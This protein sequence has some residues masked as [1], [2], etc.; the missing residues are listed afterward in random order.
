MMDDREEI[1]HNRKLLLCPTTE[2]WSAPELLRECPQCH[3]FLLYC[4]ACNKRLVSLPRSRRQANPCHHFRIIFTDGACTNNGRPEAKAGVGVAYGNDA[5]S[6]LSISITDL[7]DDFPVRSNQRAE[8]Y[9]AI[10]GLEFL[11]EADEINSH[12]QTGKPK[13]QAEAWIIATDSEY[14]VKGMTEWLP[15]WRRNNWCT[16]KGTK[17]VNLDLF[18]ALDVLMTKHEARNFKVGFWRIPR[19]HNELADRLAKAAA[20]NGHVATT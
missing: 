13:D 6:Q 4:C 20:V 9:A 2:D 3:N 14:V 5:A 18:L 1:I 16:S 10:V 19:E 7:A 8:L 15:K 12:E 17:P 11:A